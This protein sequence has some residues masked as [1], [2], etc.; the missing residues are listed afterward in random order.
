MPSGW[1]S[2]GNPVIAGKLEWEPKCLCEVFLAL[3][4]DGNVF[5]QF[6]GLNGD[7]ASPAVVY[8]MLMVTAEGLRRDAQAQ[9]QAQ[10]VELSNITTLERGET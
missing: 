4:E 10:A 8:N 6:T 2:V 3:N 1:L 7:P 9:Q 5:Y